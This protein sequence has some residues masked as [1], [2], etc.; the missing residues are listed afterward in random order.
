LKLELVA[1]EPSQAASRVKQNR[2]LVSMKS[3]INSEE[4]K[5]KQLMIAKEPDG[6]TVSDSNTRW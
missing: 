3:V 1:Q 5:E 4:V 6:D 2:N